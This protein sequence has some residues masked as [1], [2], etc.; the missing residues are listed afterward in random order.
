MIINRA[1]EHRAHDNGADD[2]AAHERGGL[3]QDD[4]STVA[5]YTLGRFIVLHEG[6]RLQTPSRPQRKPLDL[7]KA[8]IAFGSFEVPEDRLADAL[9]P[10]ADGAA[11]QQALAT[12]LHRLR[13][14][15]HPARA[16]VR[17][18]R[19]LS[20]D[21]RQCWVDLWEFEHHLAVAGRT[22]DDRWVECIE[23]AAALYRGPFLAGE[24]EEWHVP[25]AERVQA[26]WLRA[27]VALSDYWERRG[28]CDRAIDS[29]LRGLEVD[30]RA[31]E[32]YRRLMLLHAR[33]GQR[34]EAVAVY[35]RCRRVLA[36]V[37]GISPSKETEVV[38]T[39]ILI[40]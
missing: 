35:Q 14:L 9:W 16:I 37:L 29:C 6:H 22:T 10:S 3:R 13:R 39:S 20:L 30:E 11:A 38:H 4:G 1:H 12:T 8:I 32:L 26:R 19:R 18:R 40:G 24:P 25:T 31:E 7:L 15:L 28:D 5:V 21:R 33:L 27:T 2:H 17:R 36:S 23:R 34:A